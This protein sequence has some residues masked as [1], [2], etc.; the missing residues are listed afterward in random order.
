ML[1]DRLTTPA[2]RGGAPASTTSQQSELLW[3]R[4]SLQKV[5]GLMSLAPGWDGPESIPPSAEVAVNALMV[6]SS[7]AKPTTPPPAIAP[8]QDGRLQLV[9][10]AAGLEL[11]I[12]V[13]DK[14][15]AAI[16]LFEV[17]TE[18]DEEDVTL[19]DPRL[20]DAMARLSAAA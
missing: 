14:G 9:W 8:V 20:T 4:P 18:M 6:L 7:I 2:A 13:D 15:R 1:I 12:T 17:E 16:S 3:L 10:Y 11:E 5:T 19:S